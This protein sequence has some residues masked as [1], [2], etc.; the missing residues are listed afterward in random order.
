MSVIIVF[1]L[2]SGKK[3]T[4]KEIKKRSFAL[5]ISFLIK[6]LLSYLT[7]FYFEIKFSMLP[8]NIFIPNSTASCDSINEHYQDLLKEPDSEKLRMLRCVKRKI[9]QEVKI[10][11]FTDRELASIKTV[12]CNLNN[13]YSLG[14]LS[15]HEPVSLTN[16][17]HLYKPWQ[18][19][20]LRKAINTEISRLDSRIKTRIDY[21]LNKD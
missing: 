14:G 10:S 1:I 20:H 19:D 15:N 12:C 17:A 7:P 13:R 4:F 21:V 6:Y 8:E 9:G 3:I 18:D 2:F 11:H 16:R 5:F